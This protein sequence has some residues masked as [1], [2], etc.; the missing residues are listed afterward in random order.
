VSLGCP[1]FI[2]A[3]PKDDPVVRR[4]PQPRSGGN[5]SSSIRGKLL[6]RPS[7]KLFTS[8]GRPL[9]RLP[10]NVV[11]RLPSRE[12]VAGKT[13]PRP[14]CIGS[15]AR[16]WRRR[17]SNPRPKALPQ[18]DPTGVS[19][20]LSLARVRSDR[21]DQPRAS[22]LVLVPPPGPDFGT[23]LRFSDNRSVPHRRGPGSR[24]CYLSSES[25]LLVGR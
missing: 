16:W 19:G 22:P 11:L 3:S 17:E 10:V 24:R 20:L 6:F 25:H 9:R 13:K 23:S 21:R 14:R 7:F 2:G 1:R 5:P 12:R 4:V 8:R 18:R 15:A